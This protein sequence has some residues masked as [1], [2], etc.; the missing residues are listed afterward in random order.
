MDARLSKVF[1]ESEA[2]APQTAKA[3][4]RPHGIGGAGNVDDGNGDDEECGRTGF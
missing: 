1:R 2:V 4:C 3:F